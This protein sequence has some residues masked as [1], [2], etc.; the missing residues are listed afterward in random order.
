MAYNLFRNNQAVQHR[1][2]QPVDAP[3]QQPQQGGASVNPTG[4]L[5]PA[6]PIVPQTVVNPPTDVPQRQTPAWVWNEMQRQEAKPQAQPQVT[7]DPND[8]ASGM[9][10]I[11]SLYTSPEQEEK[12]RK[13]SVAN[14][15]I[16]AVADALRHMGNIYHTVKYSPSQQFNSPVAEEQQ[17]YERGKAVRD[18]AN[19]RYY[20][21]Q[22]AKAAQDAKQRQW[23][24]EFNAKNNRWA[25]E[26]GLKQKANELN[27]KKFDLDAAKHEW[28]RQYQQG[29]LD[30]KA[31]QQRIDEAY[32]KGM[33]SVAQKNAATNALN[34]STRQKETNWKISGGGGN[35]SPTSLRGKNGWYSKKMNSDESNAFYNQTYEEMKRRGLIRGYAENKDEKRAA[36]ENA[37]IEHP[38]VGDWL[39]EEFEFSFDPRYKESG[40]SLGIGIGSNSN[41]NGGKKLGIGL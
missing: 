6:Q 33:L 35:S 28:Q 3:A 16:L 39:A 8:P 10:A 7:I 11:A 32:K 2:Q 30:L 40:K 5:P 13:S 21:Y 1:P 12:M 29:T 19:M 34:A 27:W 15:R 24:A 25:A 20:S 4:Q 17:R 38:E 31:E 22:Q 9:N 26:F 41:D 36:V 23:E 14:Q 37:L 18:A